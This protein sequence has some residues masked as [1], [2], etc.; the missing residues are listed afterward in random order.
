VFCFGIGTDVN[1]HLL[2]KITEETRAASQYVL[3]EEDTEV[4]VSS[5]FSRI[6]EPVMANPELRFT[7]D[8]RVSKTYPSPLPDVFRGDQLI[9]AGR[10]S[11]NGASATVLKGMIDGKSVEIA[12]DVAFDDDKHDFI[13]RLWASRRIGFLLDE[14][15]LRGENSELRDEVVELARKHGI[16]TPYTAYLIV[17]DEARRN[18]PLTLRSMR[19]FD[20]D[21]LAR[22]R[23]GEAWNEFRTLRSGDAAVAD[24]QTAMTLRSAPAAAGVESESRRRFIQRYGLASS[25]ASP[26]VAAAPEQQTAQR[27]VEYSQQT[28]FLGGKTFFLNGGAWIDSAVQQASA[29]NRVKMKFGS[30]EYFNF[31]KDHPEALPWLA[32]GPS[33]QFLLGTTVYE[34]HE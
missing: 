29:A 10:Y 11:G 4:K 7:G 17:E 33:V 21:S 5:F 26:A 24:A 20:S 1:T 13:P 18:V 16:V 6:K 2:D 31:V 22:R 23:A 27:V 30:S 12:H 15:R 8:V 34:V 19:E 3:P 28:K 14:I 25:T 9:V 32:A